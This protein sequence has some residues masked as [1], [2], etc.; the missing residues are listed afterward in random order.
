MAAFQ[1]AEI[2]K[3][4]FARIDADADANVV[5]RRVRVH[6]VQD[7]DAPQTADCVAQ[8]LGHLGRLL[9][10]GIKD[11][12]QTVADKFEDCAANRLKFVADDFEHRVQQIEDFRRRESF[13]E[14]RKFSDIHHPDHR[15]VRHGK[16]RV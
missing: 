6:G 9:L 8:N 2:A 3:R 14:R 11:D 13:A 4:H 10:E 5:P 16:L 1:A 15:L 7:V 12:N